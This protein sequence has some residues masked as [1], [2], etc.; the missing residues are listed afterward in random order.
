LAQNARRFA[1]DVQ[2]ATQGA[3]VIT[4]HVNNSLVKPPEV[5]RSI[6]QGQI[7]IGE[8]L[9]SALGNEDPLFE[10]D[11][12]PFLASSFDQAQKLWQVT[13]PRLAQRLEQQGIVLI[14]GAPW[15]PQGIYTKKPLTTLADLAGVR[16]RVY[17]E[18]TNHMAARMAAVPVT[19][20]VPEVAQAF[21]RGTIE[22]MMTSP[23]TGVD[24][25]AWDYVKYYYDARV[26]I[27]Q[28][29]VLANKHLFALLSPAVQEAVLEA[30]QRAE[31]RGWK[32]ARSHTRALI[33]TLVAHG[34]LVQALPPILASELK[35]L[36]DTLITDWLQKTG[37]AGQQ[38]LDAYE[39]EINSQ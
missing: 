16:L 37:V 25:H 36:G 24:T 8:I 2:M 30:G 35:G 17:S 4:V 21:S 27:P 26:F 33:E 31:V 32:F 19:V 18:A 6:Q 13:R 14:Y 34:M 1:Q 3:L 28:S 20:Q 9:V 11:S 7:P 29:F 5:K 22:A 15:P 38:L 23:A 12:V 10:I 39:K